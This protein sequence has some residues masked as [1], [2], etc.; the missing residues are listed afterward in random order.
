MFDPW[1]TLQ[2]LAENYQNIRDLPY[3]RPFQILSKLEVYKGSPIT[4]D[5][6]RQGLLRWYGYS[7]KYAFLDPRIQ[8]VYDAT[9]VIMKLLHPSSSQ[10]DLFRWGNLSFSEVDEWIL[11][12]FKEQLEEINR[13][14]NRQAL[15][16]AIAIV[17]RQSSSSEPIPPAK[18]ADQPLQREAEILNELALRKLSN[19]RGEALSHKEDME[20]ALIPAEAVE[21]E[22]I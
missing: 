11:K 14:F 20:A 15:D 4:E 21:L 16:L 3:L 18:L 22:K 1:T 8:N 7:A 12:Y 19:L 5:L 2:E 13:S 10:F 6:E 17:D 9:E